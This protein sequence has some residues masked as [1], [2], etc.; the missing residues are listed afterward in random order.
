MRI[1][2]ILR[3]SLYDFATTDAGA[4]K[5]ATGAQNGAISPDIALLTCRRF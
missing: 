3:G 1:S 5:I 2:R 4:E